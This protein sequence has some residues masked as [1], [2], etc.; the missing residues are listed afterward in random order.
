MGNPTLGELQLSDGLRL[1]RCNPSFL[2]SDCSRYLAVNQYHPLFG[3]FFR[4]RMIIV[5]CSERMIWF[6]RRTPY[7]L[8][9]ESFADGTLV[10][11]MHFCWRPRR[12][13]W[14]IPHCMDKGTVIQYP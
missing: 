2:W 1:P 13:R 8:Q 10:A 9:P 6:S 4:T 14:I 11:G 7:W 5:D 12:Q 3:G